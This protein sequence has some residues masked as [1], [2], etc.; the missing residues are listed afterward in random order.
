M[1][2]WNTGK[3]IMMDL[4]QTPIPIKRHDLSNGRWYSP[5]EGWW[6]DHGEGDMPYK[7]SSTTILEMFHK[8][9]GFDKWLGDSLSFH[10]AMEYANERAQIGTVVHEMAQQLTLGAEIKFD[11]NWFDADN[12]E[13]VEITPEI[14]KY[15]MSFKAFWDD[16]KPQ[17]IATELA[18]I[19]LELDWAGTADLVA[20]MTDPKTEKTGTYLIDYKTGK[21]IYRVH[22]LQ[23]TSYRLLFESLFDI[24][25]DAIATVQLKSGWIKAPTYTLKTH[26]FIPEIW[27][28]TL[29]CYKWWANDP[30]PKWE[31]ELPTEI[32]L[33]GEEDDN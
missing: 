27:E 32:K 31:K 23:L 20:E 8:G 29:K 25:I 5:T 3:E 18:M 19:N 24:E 14:I 12:Q 4:L 7:Q 21:N 33:Y 6:K 11:D 16:W 1:N 17:P 28:H 9:F 15:I 13:V 22:Q 26:E 30:E 2:G 10:H